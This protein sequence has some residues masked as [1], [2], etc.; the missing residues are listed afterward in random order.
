[1]VSAQFFSLF[2]RRSKLSSE[3][4]PKLYK[5][6]VRSYDV[7][8]YSLGVCRDYTCEEA[9]DRPEEG[10]EIGLRRTLVRSQHS[11]AAIADRFH[12]AAV[13]KVWDDRGERLGPSI[14]KSH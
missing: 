8:R 12:N 6:I 4:K 1:M 7:H 14:P 9:S 11:V 5:A 3:N 2:N 13:S 10:T